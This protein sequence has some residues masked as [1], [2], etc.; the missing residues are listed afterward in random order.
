M[1]N[2][3]IVEEMMVII[4]RQMFRSENRTKADARQRTALSY[5]W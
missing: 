2:G 3:L 5:I 4:G 1:Q